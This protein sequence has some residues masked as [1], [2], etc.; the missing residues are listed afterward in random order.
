MARETTVWGSDVNS[1]GGSPDI[2]ILAI[3]NGREFTSE[4]LEA[5]VRRGGQ[6]ERR[7]VRELLVNRE[8]MGVVEKTPNDWKRIAG[9][10]PPPL[11][12]IPK[13]VRLHGV[14]STYCP[15]NK[16]TLCHQGD[17]LTKSR[18]VRIGW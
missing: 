5:E 9:D 18:L 4:E 13:P 16:A 6:P 15:K 1:G 2:V 12:A 11:G 17:A 8:R 14:P 3:P 10:A 7:A